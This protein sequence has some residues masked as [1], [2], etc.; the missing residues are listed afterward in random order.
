MNSELSNKT[1]L[2]V[3]GQTK[4]AEAIHSNYK[5]LPIL[6]RLGIELGFKDA[7]FK[8]IC[9]DYNL[10]L[11]FVLIIINTYNNDDYYPGQMKDIPVEHLINYIHEAH[12]YYLEIKLPEIGQLIEEL[13]ELHGNS[14]IKKSVFNSFFIDYTNELNEHIKKEEALVPYILYLNT[15]SESGNITDELTTKIRSSSFL[16]FEAE[17]SDISVKLLDLKN[18][19]I[20]YFPPTP[21]SYLKNKILNELFLFEEDIA[22][23]ARIENNILIPRVKRLEKYILNKIAT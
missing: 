4:V 11:D 22:D 18:I 17:H 8:E 20:K 15:V 23:H 12:K 14:S 19:L 7:T 16:R 1:N 3:D 6:N 2:Q 21:D 9:I 10:N 5:L 13:C